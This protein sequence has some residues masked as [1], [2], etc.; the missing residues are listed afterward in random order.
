MRD[1]NKIAE[2]VHKE[3]DDFYR[4]RGVLIHS[5]EVSGYRYP[6]ATPLSVCHRQ[7][8]AFSTVLG[9][10]ERFGRA[11]LCDQESSAQLFTDSAGPCGGSGVLTHQVCGE[12]D[13]ADLAAD[14]PRDNKPHESPAAAGVRE[15]VAAVADQG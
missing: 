4:S 12:L 5:L 1:F 10:L 11:C 9:E 7:R 2:T 14:Y 8:C 15:R 3:D 6:S 13:C